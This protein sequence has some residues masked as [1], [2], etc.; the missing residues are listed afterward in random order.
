MGDDRKVI[1]VSPAVYEALKALAAQDGKQLVDTADKVYTAG[2]AALSGPA[3]SQVAGLDTVVSPYTVD[4]VKE[5]I[6]ETGYDKDV[7]NALHRLV[8]AGRGRL[9]ALG[10]HNEKKKAEK[11][12]LQGLAP[13]KP[14]GGGQ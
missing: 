8:K 10:K 13:S 1:R 14:A 11:A 3:P 5:W 4:L 6:Q 12:V 2:L 9:G 7:T